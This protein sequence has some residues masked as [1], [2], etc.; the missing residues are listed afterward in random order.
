MKK[1]L[2]L[3][4]FLICPVIYAEETYTLIV[5]FP[6]GGGTDITARYVT[7]KVTKQ[8]GDKF[9]V[10][11]KPGANGMIGFHSM[12]ETSKSNPNVLYFGTVGTNVVENIINPNVRWN[13]LQETKTVVFLG[14]FEHQL[15]AL[16][17]SPYNKLSD[18]KNANIGTYTS[19]VEMFVKLLDIENK[20][21]NAIVP[22]K[23]EAP[24]RL[25]LLS[26]EIDIVSDTSVMTDD[27]KKKTKV[28]TSG[29]QLG[30]YGVYSI[31]A[32]KSFDEATLNTLNEKFNTVL[33]DFEVQQWLAQRNLFGSGGTP[34]DGD[35]VYLKIKSVYE[36]LK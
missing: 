31:T 9:I 7:E 14:K 21:N 33:K 22:Y 8:F 32:L 30:V 28:I 19:S 13:I 16:T 4:L 24:A 27:F 29:N 3:L 10:V 18:I 6:P 26:K 35:R 1:L 2:T 25:A 20:N 15:I 11:N 12:I 34:A 23:G 5:P 17:E 36:K